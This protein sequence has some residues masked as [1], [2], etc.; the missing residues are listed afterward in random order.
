MATTSNGYVANNTTTASTEDR[1]TITAASRCVEVQNRDATAANTL[2]VKVGTVKNPPGAASQAGADCYPI[3]GGLT[4]QSA[5]RFRIFDGSGAV[6]SVFPNGAIA[7]P[8]SVAAV[9]DPNF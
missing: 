2:W 6:V 4:S 7:S 9:D 1:A 5:R 8:Y 3:P